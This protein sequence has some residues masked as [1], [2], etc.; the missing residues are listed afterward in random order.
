MATCADIFISLFHQL[1]QL[2]RRGASLK[3]VISYEIQHLKTIK[4]YIFNCY[5]FA[6]Q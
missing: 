1:S 5:S 3:P 4:Y 6:F 2:A